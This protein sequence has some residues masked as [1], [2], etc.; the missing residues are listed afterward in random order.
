MDLIGWIALVSITVVN[1]GGWA[2]TKVYGYGKLEQ[3][4]KSLE[5]TVN[6]GL[7]ERVNEINTNV[8][9]MQGTLETYIELT[10]RGEK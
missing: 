10:K 2:Y 7:V 4:V 1:I 5:N 6:D 9:K 3:K 8:A